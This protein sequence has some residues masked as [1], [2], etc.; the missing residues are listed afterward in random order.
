MKNHPDK[1]QKQ[2]SQAPARNSQPS[3]SAAQTAF[4]WLLYG[5]TV[6]LPLKLSSFVGSGEQANFPLQAE[7]WL[8]FT[9]WPTCL[10]PVLS[11][12]VLLLA[13][14]LYRPPTLTFPRWLIPL[15][16]ACP[17]LAGLFGLVNT[18]EWDYTGNWFWHWTGIFAMS[19]A[20][21]WASESDGKLLPGLLNAIT[22]GTFICLLHGWR[23]H[24]GGLQEIYEMMEENAVRTGQPLTEAM[25]DRLQQTRIFGT[26][27][28]PNIYAAHLLLTCP[29]LLYVFRRWSSKFEPKRISFWC[30]LVVGVVLSLAAI[31]WSGSRGAVIGLAVGLVAG[32]WI[33]PIPR[34]CRIL[35]LG[36]GLVIGII[37]LVAVSVATHRDMLTAS[38]RME[39]YHTATRIF[40]RFP[41]VGAGLG[42]FQTWH[43]R[44]KPV[45]FDESRD[46]HSVL[47]SWMSQCGVPG[48][49]AVCAIFLLPLLLVFGWLKRQRTDDLPLAIA[50][51]AGWCGWLAH[52]L[53]QFNDMIPSTCTI[54][55][56][57]GL[58]FFTPANANK[59]P[60]P[61]QTMRQVWLKRI[62]LV[63]LG[64]ACLACLRQIPGEITL[65][66]GEQLLNSQSPARAL[67]VLQK[68]C[69]QLPFSPTP[70][71]LLNDY[72]NHL[73]DVPLALE[74]AQELT[75]RTPHRASSYC[76]LAKAYILNQDYATALK[77]LNTART[78]Y[79]SGPLV[80]Y[81]TALATLLQE[82]R[83]P[84]AQLSAL[85]A[86]RVEFNRD[87]PA[88]ALE[89]YL[90]LP[91][92]TPQGN[93]PPPEFL[94][95]L[96]NVCQ[97]TYEG[98]PIRFAAKPPIDAGATK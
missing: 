4:R 22:I 43:M 52:S 97:A 36:S 39:Y 26:F 64:L 55:G 81:L 2:A 69:R 56:F 28:D 3:S 67:S 17:L 42:E 44:L 20:V 29:V 75:K 5:L 71:R 96:N 15:L 33:C 8:Y 63:I 37:L 91:G 13:V 23:Q 80:A 51:S 48:L 21:W 84:P 40:A 27:A 35:L 32:L 92:E 19:T 54:A 47:F 11:G 77:V 24:F 87:F 59:S 89:F 34:K 46:A 88:D 72:A 73:G 50:V 70:P 61:A 74:S 93:P 83:M 95:Q 78:W 16:W 94:Q 65:Q 18:T 14:F 9:L 30:F 7:E 41:A 76:R 12:L 38:V 90:S 31:F 68:A 53:L 58:Y 60:V 82:Q 10:V 62:P 49:L 45:T 25:L 57:L 98:K 85:M 79:P 66:R 1:K 86:I 6:I